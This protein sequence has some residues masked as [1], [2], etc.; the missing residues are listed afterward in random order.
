M[1]A[2]KFHSISSS[3]EDDEEDYKG[4]E[5]T[6]EKSVSGAAKPETL[7]DILSKV[8]GVKY[9]FGEVVRS[10]L[11]PI[12]YSNE[13]TED[14][15]IWIVQA[16]TEMNVE[17]F[18]AADFKLDDG[19]VSHTTLKARK[20]ERRYNVHTIKSTD[21]KM[22]LVLPERETQSFH[23]SLHPIMGRIILQEDFQANNNDKSL[24][25]TLTNSSMNIV[26]IK[27]ADANEFIPLKKKKKK[28]IKQDIISS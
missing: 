7:K 14:D 19:T 24:N 27:T 10:S 6:E 12:L 4:I 8:K 5:I 3:E 17:A 21:E 18:K 25:E 15:E 28:S 9:D 16:P 1:S 23:M 22:N 11:N 2:L 20:K 13:L 26:D